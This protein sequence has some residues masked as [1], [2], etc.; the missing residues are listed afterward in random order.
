MFFDIRI[1]DIIDWLLVAFLLYQ[2][3]R[4]IRGTVAINI[5]IGFISLYFLQ[6]VV[7]AL[8][9]ELLSTILGQ[10]LGVGVVALLIVFQ[11]E[12]RKFLLLL[13]TQ[14]LSYRKF[15]L[16]SL[17]FGKQEKRVSHVD[18][19][20]IVK[21][22]RNMSNSKTGA[23]IVIQRKT[24]LANYEETGDM[25]NAQTS[26]RLIENIFFKNSPLH[27]GAVIIVRDRIRAARCV[28]PSTE[29]TNLP[30][31]YGMRHRA[32]LGI[33]ENSDAVVVVVSEETGGVSFVA[34]GVVTPNVTAEKLHDLLNSALNR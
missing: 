9:M 11:P 2:L 15:S 20:A 23:L 6:A 26:N 18:I 8:N 29:S 22:T 33:T 1:L 32:A 7:N 28:L 27:D 10:L 3:Y 4:F 13:G 5:F 34:T 31:Q 25:I 30:P 14:Y 17:L 12:I 19:D 21:A 24:S 16:R